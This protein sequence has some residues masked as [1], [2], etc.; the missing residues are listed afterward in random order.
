N[1]LLR[2][3]VNLGV[4]K[5]Q[6]IA[7]LGENYGAEDLKGRMVAVVTNLVPRKILGM[8]SE[9]MLLAAFDN[10][11]ELALLNPDKEMKPGIKVG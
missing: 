2:L 3:Q 11:G 6:S 5:R 1:K 10:S 7:G 4:E 9:V 8:D